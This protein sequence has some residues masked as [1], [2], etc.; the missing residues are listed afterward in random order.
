[1]WGIFL[2]LLPQ[3]G[4]V[5]PFLSLSTGGPGGLAGCGW[6]APGPTIELSPPPKYEDWVRDTEVPGEWVDV[7]MTGRESR[8]SLDSR[9]WVLALARGLPLHSMFQCWR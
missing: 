4:A 9:A 3:M 6:G 5:V 1:M 2:I 8:A 7:L